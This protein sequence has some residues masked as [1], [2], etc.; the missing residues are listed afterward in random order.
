MKNKTSPVDF[1][2]HFRSEIL[3]GRSL[4]GVND[5]DEE[6]RRSKFFIETM[7]NFVSS[8]QSA[9]VEKLEQHAGAMSAEAKDEFWQWHYPIH[10]E[11]IF[12]VRIRS[13]FVAQLCSHIEALLADIAHRVQVIERSVVLLKHVKGTTLEQAKLYYKAFARF[14][15]PPESLWLKMT[16]VF[17]IRNV[18]VHE[19][20]YARGLSDDTKFLAFL[21]SLP[22]VG[23]DHDFIELREGSC[24]AVL[25]IAEEFQV[26]LLAQYEGYRQRKLF[27]ED[28]SSKNA[29]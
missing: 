24:T 4:V 28:A 14:D 29:V 11:D 20:G 3:H 21:K 5:A 26:A 12:G 17:R 10:W 7:E 27:I 2:E 1:S 16:Y 6:L 22:N 13:A 19:Q 18:H 25:A 8:S 15:G 23:I 9:E